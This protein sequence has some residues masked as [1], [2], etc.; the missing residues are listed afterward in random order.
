MNLMLGI[1]VVL[2][3]AIG[4]IGIHNVY[5]FTVKVV[6]FHVDSNKGKVKV[7]VTPTFGK[8]QS[9]TIKSKEG[10]TIKFKFKDSQIPNGSFFKTCADTLAVKGG[11]EWCISEPRHNHDSKVTIEVAACQKGCEDIDP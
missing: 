1:A 7:T 9:E 8:K 6:L 11:P 10:T 5:A 4:L 2:V 3:L